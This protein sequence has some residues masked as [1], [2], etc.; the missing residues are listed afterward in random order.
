MAKYDVIVVGAGPAGSSAA[1]VLE[2][3]GLEVFLL[4]REEF[5]RAK[6]CAGVLSPKIR[7]LVPNGFTSQASHSVI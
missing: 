3:N 7:S 5:P 1:L 2:N 4:D 6:P